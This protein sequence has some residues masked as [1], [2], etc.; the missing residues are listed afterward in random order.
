MQLIS[1]GKVLR[2]GPYNELLASCPKF[3]DLVNA[4]KQ[5]IGTDTLAE[6]SKSKR[7]TSFTLKVQKHD[8]VSEYQESKGQNLIKQGEREVGDM[9][10]TPY[11]IYL[12]QSK[13]YLYFSIVALAHSAFLTGQI[14]QNTWM[15]SGVDN[16]RIKNSKLIVHY[17]IIG[18]CMTIFLF[19]RSLATVKVGMKSSKA[20]Y[21]QLAKSLFRA[22]LSFYDSTP[23]GRILTRVSMNLSYVLQC[24]L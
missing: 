21:S 3:L 5:T 6:V 8:F 9:G 23:L 1:D 14:L 15:V 16:P 12:Y 22:P 19:F 2:A 7:Q 20:I 24:S 13:G 18:L 10:F 4:H 17:V 11:L